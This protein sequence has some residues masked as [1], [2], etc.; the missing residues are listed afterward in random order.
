MKKTIALL[1][2]VALLGV[3]GGTA[4]AAPE[5]ARAADRQASNCSP[6]KAQRAAKVRV[7]ACQNDQSNHTTAY[8]FAAAAVA[9]AVAIAVSTTNHHNI[10]ASP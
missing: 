5:A 9:G 2:T 7:N 10:T 1:S 3:Q 6:M 4:F 8:V